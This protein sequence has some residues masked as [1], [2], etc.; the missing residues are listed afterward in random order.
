MVIRL[1]PCMKSSTAPLWCATPPIAMA[2]GVTAYS[3]KVKNR[4]NVAL[5]RRRRQNCAQRT[6]RR[7]RKTMLGNCAR[8]AASEKMSGGSFSPFEAPFTMLLLP[9][10]LLLLDT[11]MPYCFVAKKKLF[12]FLLKSMSVK[13]HIFLV[14]CVPGICRKWPPAGPA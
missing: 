11:F 6:I 4:R 5:E 9:L 2:A 13:T 3:T 14:Y 1:R 8:F 12:C 10:L 7:G